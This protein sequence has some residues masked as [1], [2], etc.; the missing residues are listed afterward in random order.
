MKRIAD[1]GKLFFVWINYQGKGE[2]G[3]E[4][5]PN[6][7]E[8]AQPSHPKQIYEVLQWLIQNY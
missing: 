6:T 1:E 4:D 8:T 5:K 7:H 2:G 3:G